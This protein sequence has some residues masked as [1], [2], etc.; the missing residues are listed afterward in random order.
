MARILYLNGSSA[1][2]FGDKTE[3]LKQH[4]HEVVGHLRL[5]YSVTPAARGGGLLPILTRSG[6]R[7]GAG[8]PAGMRRLPTGHHGRL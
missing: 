6:S 1:G 5:P 4:G 2:P 3:Y 7:G 8:S